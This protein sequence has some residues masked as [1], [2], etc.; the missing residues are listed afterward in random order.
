ML[1][2]LQLYFHYFFKGIELA[3]VWG[4]DYF[5][6]TVVWSNFRAS[7]KLDIVYKCT[8]TPKCEKRDLTVIYSDRKQVRCQGPGK[9]VL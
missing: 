2:V 9:N 7:D 8:L 3:A 5:N 4:M 1:I 6:G